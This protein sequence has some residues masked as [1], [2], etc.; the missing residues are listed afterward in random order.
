LQALYTFADALLFPSLAEGSLSALQ[1]AAWA[2]RG[3]IR[4]SSRCTKRWGSIYVDPRP[5][6][7]AAGL[8]RVLTDNACGKDGLRCT[9]H[10]QERSTLSET[11]Q[12]I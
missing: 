3:G 1:A 6:D 7:I 2:A 5:T 8:R 9:R 10:W 12:S 4:S 11:S